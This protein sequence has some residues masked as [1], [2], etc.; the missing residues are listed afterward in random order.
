MVSLRRDKKFQ[1]FLLRL[2]QILSI[3]LRDRK[4]VELVMNAIYRRLNL[5]F[6]L[7]FVDD[8]SFHAAKVLA[9]FVNATE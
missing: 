5:L 3:E 1:S 2:V 8:L 6:Y 9:L 4:V 7:N